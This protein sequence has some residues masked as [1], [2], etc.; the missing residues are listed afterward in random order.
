MRFAGFDDL[1]E[2]MLALEDQQEFE[3]GV[4]EAYDK[5]MSS[6]SV[7]QGH[8]R[9]ANKAKQRQVTRM[10]QSKLHNAFSKTT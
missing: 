7:F 3:N 8:L 10:R 5:I 1:Y 2:K 4:G 6:F 9:N